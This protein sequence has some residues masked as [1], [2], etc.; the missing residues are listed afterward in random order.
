MFDAYNEDETDI[1]VFFTKYAGCSNAQSG[2]KFINESDFLIG[3]KLFMN[4]LSFVIL[5]LEV[6]KTWN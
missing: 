6:M 5:F 2:I 4:L 1:K 3:K